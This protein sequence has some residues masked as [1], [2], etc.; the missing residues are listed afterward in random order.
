MSTLADQEVIEIAKRVATANDVGVENVVLAPAIASTGSPA[1]EITIVL[2]PGSS[3]TI[4]G[5]R[6]ALTISQLIQN[7]ADAGEERPPIVLYEEQVASPR[8]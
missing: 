7:L 4:L 8:S 2:K 1:I 5:E 6:S 3:R